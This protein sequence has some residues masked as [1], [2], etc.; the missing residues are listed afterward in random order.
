[1]IRKEITIYDMTIRPALEPAERHKIAKMLDGLNYE[2]MGSGQMVD[3]SE[4][5]ISFIRRKDLSLDKKG[6]IKC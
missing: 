1:M 3:G 2:I 4:C 6:K 5:D